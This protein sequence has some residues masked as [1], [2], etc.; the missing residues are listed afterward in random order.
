[1]GALVG[2]GSVGALVG[3]LSSVEA[4]RVGEWYGEDEAAGAAGGRAGAGGRFR[5]APR[6][7]IRTDEATLTPF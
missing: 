4:H 7:V 6:L 3:W 1:V 5:H 2:F